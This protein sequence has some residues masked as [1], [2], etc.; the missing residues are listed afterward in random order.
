MSYEAFIKIVQAVAQK[1]RFVFAFE[2]TQCRHTRKHINTH[3][4]ISSFFIDAQSCA[5]PAGAEK[6]FSLLVSIYYPL[7]AVIV[8]VFYAN[9]NILSPYLFNPAFMFCFSTKGAAIINPFNY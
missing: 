2:E 5:I 9:D 7:A 1:V 3:G 4:N 6:H 8:V